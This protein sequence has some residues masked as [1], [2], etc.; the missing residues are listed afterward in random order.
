[1]AD[2]FYGISR[3]EDY[4]TDAASTTNKEVEVIVDPTVVTNRNDLLVLLDQIRDGILEINW[5]PA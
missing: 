3:G 2:H 1:M 4:V 5:P